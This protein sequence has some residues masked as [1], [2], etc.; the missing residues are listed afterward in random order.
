MSEDSI[1]AYKE[2]YEN[3][4]YARQSY[5]NEWFYEK[6]LKIL[7][8]VEKN[9]YVS[10]PY[11]KWKVES[12]CRHYGLRTPRELDKRIDMSAEVSKYESEVYSEKESGK[13]EEMY[14]D[15]YLIAITELERSGRLRYDTWEEWRY[16]YPNLDKQTMR[17]FMKKYKLMNPRIMAD[18][19]SKKRY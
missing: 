18:K 9:G 1:T 14:Y 11:N 17:N 2:K 19:M 12:F 10:I 3:G 13:Y 15:K 6:Y 8:N 16:P 5:F 4:I 7:R